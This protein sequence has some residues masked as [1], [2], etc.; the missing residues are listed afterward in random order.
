MYTCCNYRTPVVTISADQKMTITG[1]DHF[2]TCTHIGIYFF[3]VLICF[4]ECNDYVD[5]PY[6][7]FFCSSVQVHGPAERF[8]GQ[9]G[10][11]SAACVECDTFRWQR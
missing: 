9:S 2:G 4:F 6:G 11:G 10:K 7:V 1:L 5:D 8:A 3:G